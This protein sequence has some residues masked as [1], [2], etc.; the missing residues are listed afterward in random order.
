MWASY[1]VK[2][3]HWTFI[4]ISMAMLVV[5]ESGRKKGS[6]CNEIGLYAQTI[7]SNVDTILDSVV[8]T[9]G[10]VYMMTSRESREY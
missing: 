10:S 9:I 4:L 2:I 7:C 1:V 8:N 6:A 5:D 3:L